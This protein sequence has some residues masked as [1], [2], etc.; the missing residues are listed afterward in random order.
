MRS[1]IHNTS[2][3][4]ELF[5]LVRRLVQ[6]AHV[7]ATDS[8]R[9][10]DSVSFTQALR[11]LADARKAAEYFLE[12]EEAERQREWTDAYAL[13]NALVDR[14]MG[15]ANIVEALNKLRRDIADAIVG[16]ISYTAEDRRLGRRLVTK[17]DR[18]RND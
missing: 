2:E 3:W 16:N 11:D 9:G 14:A 10:E 17:T 13:A 1:R 7:V 6:A 15:T 12:P 4:D 5:G 8:G 18:Q